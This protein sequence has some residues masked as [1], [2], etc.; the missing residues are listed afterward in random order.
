MKRFGW[1]TLILVAVLLAVALAVYYTPENEATTSAENDIPLRFGSFQLVSTITGQE[2]LT[3]VESMHIGSLGD[4]KDAVIATYRDTSSRTVQLWIADFQ[5]S[6]VA[7]TTLL[8]MV[9]AI[10]QYPEIGFSAPE[11]RS[12]NGIDVY[13]SNGA[14]GVNTFWA[15]SNSVIYLLISQTSLNDAL[16]STQIFMNQ[17]QQNI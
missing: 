13:V 5:N 3:S 11:K 17:Y 4:I 12:L 1:Y 14:G 10:K 9:D 15:E 2:A 7:T 6:N 16:N 8:R